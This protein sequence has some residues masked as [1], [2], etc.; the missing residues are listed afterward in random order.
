MKHALTNPGRS[1][2]AL[3]ALLA[4]ALLVGLTG[5][6][7]SRGVSGGQTAAAA[8]SEV[9]SIPGIADPTYVKSDSSYSGLTKVTSTTVH[10]SINSEHHIPDPEALVDFLIRM[11]WSVNDAK[12]NRAIMTVAID[13]AAAL[14][15]AAA[16]QKAGWKSAFSYPELPTTI[17]V[18]L[19]EA[20]KRLGAWPGKVPKVPGGLIVTS[21]AS[22]AP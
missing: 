2:R 3:A 18:K 9:K 15:V 4:V 22:P 8:M 12:P 11:A 1:R 19:S 7:P 21:T 14:D 16:A 17:F 10:V 20:K 6:F 5:C 13:S